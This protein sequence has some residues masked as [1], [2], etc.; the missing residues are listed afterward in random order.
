MYGKG[1]IH[2]LT[3]SIGSFKLVLLDTFWPGLD[4]PMCP[5]LPMEYQSLLV[6]QGL[7]KSLRL[8]SANLLILGWEWSVKNGPG[9]SLREQISIGPD[10][11]FLEMGSP[12]DSDCPSFFFS[13]A[14]EVGYRILALA[15]FLHPRILF[16]TPNST[17]LL[18]MASLGLVFRSRGKIVQETQS[19]QILVLVNFEHGNN[20]Y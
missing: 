7:Y 8:L 12:W 13:S 16:I 18:T 15:F 19:V 3:S 4:S 2:C 6:S 10:V 1:T 9:Q 14:Q 20:Q 5:S 11:W 17:L